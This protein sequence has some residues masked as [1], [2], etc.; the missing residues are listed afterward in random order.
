MSSPL[1]A[2]AGR[3]LFHII[4]LIKRVACR[5]KESMVQEIYCVVFVNRAVGVEAAGLV[6][7]LLRCA[8]ENAVQEVDRVVFID[9][10]IPARVACGY[11]H[12][13]KLSAVFARVQFRS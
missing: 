9:G 5:T 11:R 8:A 6:E 7:R 4:W 12:I 10:T 3:G 1:P 13:D 2:D